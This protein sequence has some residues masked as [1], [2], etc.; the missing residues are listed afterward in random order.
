LSISAQKVKSHFLAKKF[1]NANFF[2]EYLQRSFT[3]GQV[4]FTPYSSPIPVP[5]HGQ[6][7][8]GGNVKLKIVLILWQK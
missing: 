5:L 4:N 8:D 7:K 2:S 1:G 3:V 6:K